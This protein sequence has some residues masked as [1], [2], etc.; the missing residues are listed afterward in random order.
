MLLNVE[1][2]VLLLSC[3]MSLLFDRSMLPILLCLPSPQPA[4]FL[5]LLDLF[6]SAQV[7]FSSF[8][9]LYHTISTISLQVSKNTSFFTLYWLR[10]GSVCASADDSSLF[11][12]EI[13][14]RTLQ[15]HISAVSC[16]T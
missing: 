12:T 5:A 13:R 6:A 15:A 11:Q 2:W 10:Q 14:A 9:T 4:L 7:F 3:L 16:K 8:R 1:H